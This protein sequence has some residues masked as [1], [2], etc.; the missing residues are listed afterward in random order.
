MS[1]FK[2][3]D[4][5]RVMP[6][7][8]NTNFTYSEGE[9]ETIRSI[10]GDVALVDY[11]TGNGSDYWNLDELVLFEEQSNSLNIL[12]PL[13]ELEALR[14]QVGDLQA[15]I[16]EL[17]AELEESA[18]ELSEVNVWRENDKVYTR[19]L[20]ADLQAAQDD[21]LGQR[22]LASL[23]GKAL[24]KY[25]HMA[26]NF[27]E[28]I[29]QTRKEVQ[30]VIDR[31]GKDIDE[32]NSIS[33][34]RIAHYRLELKKTIAT[35]KASVE[36]P[37]S[38][39]VVTLTGLELTWLAHWDY[40]IKKSNNIFSFSVP[41]G[42]MNVHMVDKMALELRLV[43]FSMH[44]WWSLMPEYDTEANRKAI[45]ARRQQLSEKV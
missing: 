36:A 8:G 9:F 37:V 1:N 42:E 2:A 15:L 25:S 41:T 43:D 38:T 39:E 22:T 14:Q 4:K 17:R 5:V 19:K 30:D 26:L 23:R 24:E 21:L 12:Q 11:F 45:E 31:L 32:H 13:A 7:N 3:G 29:A 10:K 40:C 35:D 28:N 44:N 33:A 27:A 34:P 6:K 18:K 16:T 20:E